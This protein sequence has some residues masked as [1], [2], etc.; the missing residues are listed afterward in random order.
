MTARRT[1]PTDLEV[2]VRSLIR[3]FGHDS[4]HQFAVRTHNLLRIK[5][6]FQIVKKMPLSIFAYCSRQTLPM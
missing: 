6:L 2:N 4:N 3:F 5:R 1:M